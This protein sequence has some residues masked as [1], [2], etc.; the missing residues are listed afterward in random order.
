[1]P[2]Q[3]DSTV[4]SLGFLGLQ[5]IVSI[6][7]AA[8]RT[9]VVLVFGSRITVKHSFATNLCCCITNHSSCLSYHWYTLVLCP[10][11]RSRWLVLAYNGSTA[12]SN[13]PPHYFTHLP[14][15]FQLRKTSRMCLNQ[16]LSRSCSLSLSLSFSLPLLAVR[17]TH[18]TK[19]KCEEN[20][21]QK[22]Q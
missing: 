7:P 22:T 3:L 5:C 1:M 2:L 12:P 17:P 6:Q 15:L 19:T 13:T 16:V 8:V 21:K 11:R 9:T 4:L 18:K 10:P 20:K 14:S